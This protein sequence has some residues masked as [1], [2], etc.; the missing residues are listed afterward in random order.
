MR[1]KRLV[2]AVFCALVLATA[3]SPA[4]AGCDALGLLVLCD[5]SGGPYDPFWWMPCENYI[6]YPDQT[7]YQDNAAACMLSCSDWSTFNQCMSSAGGWYC[8]QTGGG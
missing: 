1:L 5:N 2:F 4:R 6:C 7:V 8:S 3:A